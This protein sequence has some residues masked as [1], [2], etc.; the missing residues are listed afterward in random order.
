MTGKCRKRYKPILHHRKQPYKTDN[1]ITRWTYLLSRTKGVQNLPK[2]ASD[3]VWWRP[4]QIWI[5]FQP[6]Q[7]CVSHQWSVLQGSK[8]YLRRYRDGGWSRPGTSGLYLQA[9]QRQLHG[10]FCN[11]IGKPEQHIRH[12]HTNHRPGVENEDACSGKGTVNGA[13]EFGRLLPV[14][15]V[16]CGLAQ[17]LQ[18]DTG[19][20]SLQNSPA[21][22]SD[23]PPYCKN[24]PG[25]P[26]CP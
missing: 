21:I 17:C 7:P 26:Q 9:A 12:Q 14:P 3:P 20:H 10:R 25:K 11:Q 23:C 5:P 13:S 16:G 4:K 15:P 19:R 2:D 22:S 24:S 8:S 18:T 6:Q 1:I